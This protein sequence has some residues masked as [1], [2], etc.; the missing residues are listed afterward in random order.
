MSTSNTPDRPDFVQLQYAF[1]A[2]IRNPDLNPRPH[3]I[4]ERRMKIYCELFYNNVEDFMANT[5]PVLHSIISDE[6]WHALIR[7]YFSCHRSSTPLFPEMPREFLKYLE[8]ERAFDPADPPFMSELAHYEWVELALSILD[9]KNDRTRFNAYGDVLAGV[10][11]VSPLVWVLNYC[12]PVHQISPEFQPQAPGEH[13]THLVVYRD[14]ED[15]I[16]FIESNPVTTRLLQ[17][18]IDNEHMNGQ[19]LLQQI[20]TE[21]KHPQPDIVINGGFEIMKDFISRGILLGVRI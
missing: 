10:P 20:A 3:D 4:E 11:V 15:K 5:F 19:V 12:F 6:R 14:K 13:L 21:L 16:H 1:A 2:H 8:H 18:M 17:L 9:E 7:D